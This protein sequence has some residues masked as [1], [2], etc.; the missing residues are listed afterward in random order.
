[1]PLALHVLWTEVE[2]KGFFKGVSRVIL[3]GLVSLS[4]VL[5]TVLAID[6]H[7]YRRLAFPALN[8]LIYNIGGGPPGAGDELYGVRAPGQEFWGPR[9]RARITGL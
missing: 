5:P 1:M 9:L 8:I 4:L 6:H 3:W 7:F 2:S